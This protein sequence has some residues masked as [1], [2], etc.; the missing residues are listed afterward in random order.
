MQALRQLLNFRQGS[1]PTRSSL[2]TGF[3]VYHWNTYLSSDCLIH[4]AFIW[5]FLP[6]FCML[7]QSLHLSQS[8]VPSLPLSPRFCVRRSRQYNLIWWKFDLISGFFVFSRLIVCTDLN[9][10]CGWYL[11][12][13]RGCLSQSQVPSL[14]L[15]APGSVYVGQG[16]TI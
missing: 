10:N 5:V 3:L 11:A 1:G 2:S 9:N 14:P 12:G 7:I 4:P 15:L 6:C 8:W 16:S 13:G